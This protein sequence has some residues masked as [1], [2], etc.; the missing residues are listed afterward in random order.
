MTYRY[1]TR[2]G[3]QHLEPRFPETVALGLKLFMIKVHDAENPNGAWS[4]V[5]FN[6]ILQNDTRLLWPQNDSIVKL[7]LSALDLKPCPPLVLD[8]LR[9]LDKRIL[10]SSKN[11]FYIICCILAGN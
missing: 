7:E 9:K 8:R 2:L 6:S 4:L 10:Y 1:V 11:T 3:I 5:E